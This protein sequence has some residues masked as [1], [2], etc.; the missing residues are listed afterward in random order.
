M[1]QARAWSIGGALP[2][3][4]PT[5]P[6]QRRWAVVAA[7]LIAILV[8]AQ[9]ATRQAGGP[10][11][12]GVTVGARGSDRV[13]ERVRYGGLAWDA[14]VRPGDVVLGDMARPADAGTDPTGAAPTST[15]LV[16]LA[17]GGEVLVQPP[18]WAPGNDPW[19]AIAFAL[20]MVVPFL[21]VGCGVYVLAA[22]GAS[23]LAL[24]AVTVVAA[25]IAIGTTPAVAPTPAGGALAAVGLR[26]LGGALL[27]LFLLFPVDRVRASRVGGAVLGINLAATV[28]VAALDVRLRLPEAR[29]SLPTLQAFDAGSNGLLAVQVVAAFG[30]AL[31]ALRDGRRDAARPPLILIAL[32]TLAGFGPLVAIATLPMALGRD[33]LPGVALAVAATPLF[34]LGLGAAVLSRQFFGITRL[35]RRGLVALAVWVTLVALYAFCLA[36]L[37]R[38]VAESSAPTGP[39]AAAIGVAVAAV[40]ATFP[41]AQ[42]ALRRMLE[43]MLFRDVYD[44]AET[45]RRLSVE[46]AGLSGVEVIARHLLERLGRTLDLAWAE[47][48]V[49]AD[50]GA[51]LRFRWPRQP[52]PAVA[53][54][55][56]SASLLA[57][58][59]ADGAAIGT[60]ALGQ[61]RRDVD[62]LPEDR[63]LVATL[64]P[65][66]ARA[67]QGG[68]LL[69]RLEE[70]VAELGERERELAGLSARLM[71]AQEEERRRLALDLHDDPLQRAILLEREVRAAPD[72]PAN[73]RWRGMVEEIALSLRAIGVGLRPPA[74]DDFGLVAAL[75]RLADDVRGR[76]DDVTVSLLVETDDGAPFGRLRPDLETALYRVAQEALNNCLKHAAPDRITVEVRRCRRSLRLRVVDD[77]RGYGVTAADAATPGL[78]LL[79]MRERVRPWGGTVAIA[80]GPTGG[81][82]L[83][84]VVNLPGGGG[85]G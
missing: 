74:L 22:D 24:L 67:L 28:A 82:V 58:L 17:A 36:A 78:G 13:V 37:W 29:F 83:E 76:A 44:Y 77:G 1:G 68:L 6:P 30:L 12:P 84:V 45:L 75:D 42:S 51:P 26:G 66:L 2:G 31:L 4:L 56:A 48:V 85:G 23:A 38:A 65:L 3:A 70:Q 81:S 27:A 32:G 52:D 63:E 35:V 15:V 62:L 55:G 39:G 47:V 9:W 10:P 71:R 25:A 59:V 34:P 69:H 14:G 19:P 60:L 7:V 20:L 50:A 8:V 64:M 41:V 46:I 18:G 73:R 72:L 21:A 53:V 16:R 57:P 33:P 40:A 5:V 11:D 49:E 79:G 43:R 80:A 54:D 61:K